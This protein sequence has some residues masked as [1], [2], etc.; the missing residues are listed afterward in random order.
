MVVK[1]R[2]CPA[3]QMPI[4]L[5]YQCFG[6]PNDGLPPV[7]LIS[8]LN[9]QLYAWDEEFC[10][11]LVRAGF[12]VV[13]YDNR[14]MGHSTKVEHRGRVKAPLLLL[15]GGAA[16]W[17]GEKL[18]YSVEDMAADAWALL[19][20]LQ[21]PCAHL[22]GIS[23]GGMIAQ[24]AALLAPGRT[25]SL[26]SVMSSTNAAD[27]PQP[28]LWVKLWMLRRPP[29]HCTVDELLEFRVNSLRRLLRS[30]LPPDGEYLK[31][32]FLMSLKR[33]SYSAGLVRQAAA[34]RRAAGR[35]AALQTLC[36][37]ALV[38]HGAQDV[39]V[40]PMH[41][42]RTATMLPYARM[43]VLKSMGHYFHPAFFSTIIEAFADMAAS[44]DPTR[45]RLGSRLPSANT[46]Q[47]AGVVEKG[48]ATD[49]NASAVAAWKRGGGFVTSSL[50][51]EPR[52][53]NAEASPA[54]GAAPPPSG[55]PDNSGK[56]KS[57][58]GTD[59]STEAAR[60][61]GALSA[62]G[63]EGEAEEDAE[64][65]AEEPEE[66]EVSQVDPR[67]LMMA[68]MGAFIQP[69]V[70]DASSPVGMAACRSVMVAVP[71]G[72]S[73]PGVPEAVIV[74]N[75]FLRTP[76]AVPS[77][78]TPTVVK[79]PISP[80]TSPTAKS[81]TTSALPAQL[82]R[83]PHPQNR[84]S[85]NSSPSPATSPTTANCWP[86]PGKV[87]ASP[88]ATEEERLHHEKDGAAFPR[89]PPMD[90]ATP[91][92]PCS[93]SRWHD[94]APF[95]QRST[96]AKAKNGATPASEAQMTAYPLFHPVVVG[97]P[98]GEYLETHP[99]ERE[100]SGLVIAAN[101]AG[102]SAAAAAA[103][104]A[105]VFDLHD[106]RVGA[107]QPPQ[108]KVGGDLLAKTV[109]TSEAQT[110]KGASTLRQSAPHYGTLPISLRLSPAE[111]TD[112]ASSEVLKTDKARGAEATHAAGGKDHEDREATAVAAATAAKEYDGCRSPASRSSSQERR[113]NE[114]FL[115]TQA[116]EL[117]VEAT[118]LPSM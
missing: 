104:A 31:K 42:Y 57:A 4:E 33:S 12:Y 36:V 37:P 52:Q 62:K 79:K 89:P 26:T 29:R 21:I 43:L 99:A 95:P 68:S 27:L 75:M 58:D 112:T 50:A 54:S 111:L 72:S 74:E 8:G 93:P 32:R 78:P 39:V 85:H 69:V 88:L 19:D 97:V 28:Q 109:D 2:D 63:K 106:E 10:E 96:N 108:Q 55:L 51:S 60:E 87:Y 1:V 56:D 91:Y 67:T 45:R 34:I 113:E 53:C 22:F 77:T 49:G 84:S 100:T 83:P 80:A 13:R 41:G 7:L 44:T 118:T 30:A 59:P 76:H 18:P 101:A 15:P 16:T 48:R 64:E 17:F 90:G 3:S 82:M 81:S 6:D 20:T 65:S 14:D 102:A 25:M 92:I 61:D 47:L 103:A 117:L 115:Q 86:L 73:N 110:G 70:A 23:M 40:P 94:A 114:S 38:V 107:P 5:C 105:E 116:S 66:G 35:D 24:A 11:S 46:L 98:V 9:M 71:G